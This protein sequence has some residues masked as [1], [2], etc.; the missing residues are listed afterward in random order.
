MLQ[1]WDKLFCHLQ[2][3]CKQTFTNCKD[4]L[5]IGSTNMISVITVAELII[6]QLNYL[7]KALSWLKKLLC[8]QQNKFVFSLICQ[9]VLLN[10][11][12][13]YFCNSVSWHD[14]HY[15]SHPPVA[16]N[17]KISQLATNWFASHMLPQPNEKVMSS[18]EAL[19]ATFHPYTITSSPFKSKQFLNKLKSY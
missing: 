1:P 8:K 9:H 7:Q 6:Y 5:H 19:R 18:S 15:L 16:I 12:S 11:P 4:S 17:H 3:S 14:L 10:L 2:L 13:S